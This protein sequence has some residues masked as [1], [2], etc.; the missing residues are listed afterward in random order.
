[1]DLTYGLISADSH[2]AFAPDTYTSRM[3]AKKWG[4]LIPRVVEV[5]EN[6]NAIDRWS[7]YGEV[8]NHDI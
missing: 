3:S 1:M 8:S 7:I 6:G 4:D 5:K 2:A